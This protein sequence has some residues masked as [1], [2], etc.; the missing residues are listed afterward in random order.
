MPLAHTIRRTAAAALLQGSP[1]RLKRRARKVL[2]GPAQQGAVKAVDMTHAA[3]RVVVKAS[4]RMWRDSE[5]I[6]G[7]LFDPGLLDRLHTPL[8]RRREG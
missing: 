6:A 2:L 7:Q 5:G 1:R 3:L 8:T 4:A